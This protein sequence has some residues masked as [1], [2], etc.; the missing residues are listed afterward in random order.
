MNFYRASCLSHWVPG[1]LVWSEYGFRFRVASGWPGEGSSGES[2]RAGRSPQ[3]LV[4]NQWIQPS[5]GTS[6]RGWRHPVCDS[7]LGA[8]AE[9]TAATPSLALGSLPVL[10]L[11][12]CRQSRPALLPQPRAGSITWQKPGAS[13]RV[14]R[15]ELPVRPSGHAEINTELPPAP[16]HCAPRQRVQPEGKLGP[17]QPFMEETNLALTV[18]LGPSR[19]LC[20]TQTRTNDLDT[21]G[22]KEPGPPRAQLEERKQTPEDCWTA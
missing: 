5:R 22:G 13:K 3:T 6:L 9:G 1:G 21:M 16:Y 7:R 14:L 4:P 18:S 15:A 8:G 20:R 2:P 19:H 10:R 17:D 12:G 11:P